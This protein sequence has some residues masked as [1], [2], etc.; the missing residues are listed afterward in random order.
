MQVGMG[1]SQVRRRQFLISL[2]QASAACFASAAWAAPSSQQKERKNIIFILTDDHGAHDLGCYGHT[3][4]STPNIDRLAR[5][6]A[7][8]TDAY[9]P[10]AVCTP[11]RAANMTG[12]TPGKLHVTWLNNTQAYQG[13]PEDRFLQT[14]SRG[15]LSPEQT[16]MAECLRAR[17]YSTALIGKW[18]LENDPAQRGFDTVVSDPLAGKPKSYFH[19]FGLKNV[20]GKEG[21]YLTDNLTDSAIAHIE[22]CHREGK[23][24]F[25]YL[26]HHAPHYPWQGKPAQVK[27]FQERGVG[28]PDDANYLAMIENLDEGVGRLVNTL[29]KLGIAE[30][31]VL[32]LTGDNGPARAVPEHPFKGIKTSFYEGGFRVPFIAWG[33]GTVLPQVSETPVSG[34]DIMPTALAVAGADCPR[35]VEGKNLL[36]LLAEKK[37]LPER[38]LYWHCPHYSAYPTPWPVPLAPMSAIRKGNWKL[39]Y[40]EEQE[41]RELYDLKN[42]P[43]EKNDLSEKMPEKTKGLYAELMRWRRDAS[44]AAPIPR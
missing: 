32:F 4:L 8:F 33:P 41:R 21:D 44:V 14:H 24:F 31:T 26:A 38:A 35:E 40:F 28:H 2:A 39:I 23:P 10:A 3:L 37:S 42:D 6:G 20:P 5:E 15:E 22:K 16:T 29:E 34:I 19:P 12:Q 7:R 11:S 17:G 36:P 1:L 9:A 18:H 43:G 13:K 27:K 25:L 30:K